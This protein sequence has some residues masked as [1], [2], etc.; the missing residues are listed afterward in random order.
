MTPFDEVRNR[1]RAVKAPSQ[2]GGFPA[3][4]GDAVTGLID[5]LRTLE[6]QQ[7]KALRA[8]RPLWMVAAASYL[9]ILAAMVVLPPNAV[10]PS[11]IAFFGGLAGVFTLNAALLSR[12]LRRLAAVDYTESVASFLAKA[13][14]RFEFM[15]R[16]DR[17]ISGVGLLVLGLASGV[18]V[19]DTLIPR[20]VPVEYRSIAL[21]LF[22]MGYVGLCALGLW[23]TYRR[24]RLDRSEA[25]SEIRHL[26]AELAKDNPGSAG[27][28]EAT[29]NVDQV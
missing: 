1:T 25:W 10:R 9:L 8:A 26:R 5:R 19:A 15:S 28:L 23:L 24:W 27:P 13:E 16:G 18:Y 12:H 17:W 21:G 22:G 4:A 6:E 29:G 20:Y 2:P 11:Q 7:A 3:S 14:R